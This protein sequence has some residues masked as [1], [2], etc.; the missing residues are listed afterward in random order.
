MVRIIITLFFVLVSVALKAQVNTISQDTAVQLLKDTSI[1]LLDVRTPR[2]FKEGHIPGALHM[3]VQA[4]ETFLKQIAAL[5]KNKTYIVYCRSGVRSM[6]AAE[7][8]QQNGFRQVLNMEQGI[9][10]WKGTIIQ[11]NNQ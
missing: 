3:D 7:L 11:S 2:E 9:L 1:R 4:T 8:M 10:G 6:K 5:P